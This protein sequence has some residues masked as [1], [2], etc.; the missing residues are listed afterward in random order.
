MIGDPFA[1]LVLGE[2]EKQ[3]E[4]LTAIRMVV[5]EIKALDQ[6]ESELD[7]VWGLSRIATALDHYISRSTQGWVR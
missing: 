6:C 1:H 7:I 2:L 3:E 4:R 5:G